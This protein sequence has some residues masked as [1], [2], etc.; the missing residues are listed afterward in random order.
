M[1]L[2]LPDVTAWAPG[3]RAGR[4]TQRVHVGGERE[5]RKIWELDGAEIRNTWQ[6]WKD[7]WDEWTPEVT[8]LTLLDGKVTRARLFQRRGEALEAVG[9][10][11]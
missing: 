3:A 2:R 4:D 6:P 11:Q 5:D 7:A 9:L 10:S 8:A 1:L